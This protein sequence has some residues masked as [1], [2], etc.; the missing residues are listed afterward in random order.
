MKKFIFAL[1]FLSANAFAWGPT[2]HRVVGAVAEK[3]LEPS[4]A[5]KVYEILDGQN[6]ARV[7]TWPDEIRSEPEKYSYTF[8]WHFTDWKDDD[9]T[10]DE[11]SSS[12]KLLSAIKEQ[13]AVLKDPAA[14]KDKKVFALR[15]IVHLV[16]DLHQ[17]LHV[18][19][20]LDQGGNKCRVTFMGE[21]TNLHSV[22]DEGMINFT[23][24]SF[25][26]IA[27]FVSQGRTKEQVAAW[28]SGDVVDWALES[29]TLRT[30]IY[31]AEVSTPANQVM[32][33]KQ[34]CRS[35]V[36]VA[37]EDMPK[38]SYEYSY[39]FVPVMEERLFQAGI[40]LAMLL[41]QALK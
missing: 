38:L 19:N 41:N 23:K 6:L 21:Q 3:A 27:S 8:N 20:G 5:V 7:S 34:Y 16:G 11:S 28:K 26:E 37:P 17:P 35:D 14:A 4:V 30:T 2:G 32:S 13:L 29:K 1:M 31:P 24:L 25:T 39:K 22:W 10:H 9:H 12:G 36:K 18:G 33:V 40:R 15:F